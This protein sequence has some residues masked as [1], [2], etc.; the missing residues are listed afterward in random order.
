MGDYDRSPMSRNE[1]ILRATI[2]GTEYK[3]A[4][5]SAV[6]E[7]LLELKEKIEEG[8][9]SGNSIWTDPVSASS[10]AESVT[11]NHA[12]I[13]TTSILTPYSQNNSGT[14]IPLSSIVASEG[15]AVITFAVALEEATSFRLNIVN[16]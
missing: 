14:V 10:G 16:L 6:E 1:E 12:D 5:M 7:L 11:I 8:G 2:D 9:G 13:H 4:P 15:S 3:R